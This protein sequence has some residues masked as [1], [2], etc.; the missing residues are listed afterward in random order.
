M[1]TFKVRRECFTR[2]DKL[3]ELLKE[4]YHYIKEISLRNVDE[5]MILQFGDFYRR[6]YKC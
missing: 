5:F 1:C 3:K 2:F 4:S 6:L